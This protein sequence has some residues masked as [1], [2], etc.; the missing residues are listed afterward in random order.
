MDLTL[1]EFKPERVLSLTSVEA[2]VGQCQF[3]QQIQFFKLIEKDVTEELIL[4][5]S[6][7]DLMAGSCVKNRT[8]SAGLHRSPLVSAMHS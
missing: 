5:S 1:L 4:D 3:L 2:E 8:S 6:Q 7:W